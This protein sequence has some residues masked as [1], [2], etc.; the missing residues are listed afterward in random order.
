MGPQGFE[1]P[2]E[3]PAKRGISETG[4]AKS[5]ALSPVSTPIDP[6]LAAITA[7]WPELPAALKAGIVAMVKAATGSKA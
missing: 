2:A 6:D 3:T 4:G 1:Q 7:A 5:G